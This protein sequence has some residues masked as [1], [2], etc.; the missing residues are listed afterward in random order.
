VIKKR[1]FTFAPAKRNKFS[2]KN[3]ENNVHRHIE[4][5][6]RFDGNIETNKIKRVREIERFEKPSIFV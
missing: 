2:D 4:L 5:T 1:F 6:A 3:K